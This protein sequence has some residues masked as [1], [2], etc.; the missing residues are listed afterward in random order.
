MFLSVLGKNLSCKNI[1][2]SIMTAKNIKKESPAVFHLWRS[3][4]FRRYAKTLFIIE[5]FFEPALLS[6]TKSIEAKAGVTNIATK[7]EAVREIMTSWGTAMTYCPIC[8]GRKRRGVKAATVVRVA[9]K[10]GTADSKAPSTEALMLSIPLSILYCIASDMTM[11]LSTSI[12]S[13]IISAVVDI[14]CI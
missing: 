3:P 7:Y 5:S 10:T 1:N 11:A 8:P 13:E 12:P 14:W 6:G 4:L 2:P 9:V